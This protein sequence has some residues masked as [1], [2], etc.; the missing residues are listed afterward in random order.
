MDFFEDLV[1]LMHQMIESASLSFRSKLHCIKTVFIVLSGQGESLSIDP[2]KFYASLYN[3]ILQLNIAGDLDN[4]NLLAECIDMMFFRR[5]KQIPSARLLAFIK[6]LTIVS[7]QLEP[8][9]AAIVLNIVQKLLVLNKSTDLLFDNEYQDSGIYNPELNEP[10][11]AN[12]QNTALWELHL[13]RRHYNVSIRGEACDLLKQTALNFTELKTTNQDIINR[14][15][16]E[17]DSILNDPINIK[18]KNF[19]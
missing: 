11:Y 8:A 10:D 2:I 9:S 13:L 1:K 19:K 14:I 17:E 15:K 16:K 3:I 12:A 18:K 7:T 4:T 6:R 5:R